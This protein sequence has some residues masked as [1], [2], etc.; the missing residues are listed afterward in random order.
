MRL[1]FGG[2]ISIK[3]LFSDIS[4][5]NI[6]RIITVSGKHAQQIAN[7]IFPGLG[8]FLTFLIVVGGFFFNIGNVAG[9]GL[10]LNVL[11]GISAENGAVIAAVLAIIVFVVRNALLVMDRTVQVLAVVK[12]AVLIYILSV[13]TVPVSSAIKHTF[14]PSNIDFYSIVTIVGGT[15][16]GYISFAGGHRLLEGGVHGQ[17]GLKYVNEGALSG[18]GIASVIRVMLFLAG[19]AVVMAG[20][21]LDP[22]NPAADIFKIAAGN[23]GYKFFGLLLFAAGMTSILGSTFTS[24]SFMNYSHSPEGAVKFQKYRPYLVIGFIAVSTLVFYIVG[25]PAQILVVVGAINGLILPIA[26]AILLIGAYK[27]KIMGTDYKHPIL[28]SIF[29]WIVVLF[30]AFAGIET[31]IHTL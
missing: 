26:L 24:V 5:L 18:I 8:Y 19:L 22:L 13:T 4:L 11:F 20:H 30:M 17:K 15:V 1:S 14:L 2:A 27:N 29:G 23:F 16:G 7:D 6:W 28:L 12:I 3:P 21:K 25:K 31:L 10:G 9:A